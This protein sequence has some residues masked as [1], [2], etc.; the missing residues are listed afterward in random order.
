MSVDVKS[1]LNGS[2]SSSSTTT[3]TVI[4]FVDGLLTVQTR[5]GT[6]TFVPTD[7]TNYVAGDTVHLQGDIVIGKLTRTSSLPTYFV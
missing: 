4:S 6:K 5:K 7:A 2:S 1:L 3:G